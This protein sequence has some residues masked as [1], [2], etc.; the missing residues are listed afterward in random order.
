M[1]VVDLPPAGGDP[2]RPQ[3]ASVSLQVVKL[4]KMGSCNSKPGENVLS[5]DSKWMK[6]KDERNIKSLE[7]CQKNYHFT[8]RLNRGM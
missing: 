4:S 5:G 3:C 1:G 7:N 8:G 6:E 2:H